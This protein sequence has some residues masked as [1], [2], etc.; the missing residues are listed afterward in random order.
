[1]PE[2]I[3]RPRSESPYAW[4]SFV[5]K[6]FDYRSD[7]LGISNSLDVCISLY[8]EWAYGIEHFDYE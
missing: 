2:L 4:Y 1:M 8:L 3:Y 5:D 6:N 7:E